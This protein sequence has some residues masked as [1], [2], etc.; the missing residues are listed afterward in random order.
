MTKSGRH[1][2]NHGS[3]AGGI[4][5]G[6]AA[7]DGSAVKSHSTV[8]Q[9]LCRQISLDYYTIPPATQ[10]TYVV[11]FLLMHLEFVVFRKSDSKSLGFLTFVDVVIL[12]ILNS[13]TVIPFTLIG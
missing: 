4:S 13:S 11:T 6:F 7:R 5:R 12:S 9:R 10:A 1:S 8:L 2:K 3:L